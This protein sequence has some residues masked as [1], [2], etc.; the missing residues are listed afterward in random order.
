MLA[1]WGQ[2]SPVDVILVILMHHFESPKREAIMFEVLMRLGDKRSG[3]SSLSQ[4]MLVKSTEYCARHHSLYLKKT[5]K[6]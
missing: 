6:I 2:K 3:A 5:R 4:D 1:I